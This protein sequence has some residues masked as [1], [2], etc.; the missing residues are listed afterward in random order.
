MADPNVETNAAGA[1]GIPHAALRQ[2]L[3]A[4]RHQLQALQVAIAPGTHGAAASGGGPTTV[5]APPALSAQIQG[6]R[7]QGVLLKSLPKPKK[8]AGLQW[9]A[10]LN[11]NLAL[12]VENL[13]SLMG[14]IGKAWS[15]GAD[16][17][18]WLIEDILT[19]CPEETRNWGLLVAL[20]GV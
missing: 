8:S 12:V 20:L 6:R 9:T 11:P 15:E 7:A 17:L 18:K 2:Q 13:K 19:S 1:T 14:L 16:M 10:H 4:L 3:A 5:S